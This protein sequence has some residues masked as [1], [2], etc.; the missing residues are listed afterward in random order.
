M[1]DLI[2]NYVALTGFADGSRRFAVRPTSTAE[3]VSGIVNNDEQGTPR[4]GVLQV[5]EFLPS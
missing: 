2:L 5:P 4:R 3:Q 1:G